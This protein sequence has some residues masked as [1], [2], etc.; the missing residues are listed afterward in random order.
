MAA[1]GIAG[2]V[3]YQYKLARQKVAW[4]NALSIAESG[5]NYYQWHLA[6]NPED[7]QDG[8]GQPG[9]YLHDYQDPYGGTTGQFSLEITAPNSCSNTITI[10]STGWTSGAPNTQRSA[11]IKYGKKSLAD[12]AFL[13]N[14][15]AWFGPDE[16]LHGPVHSNGGI[17]QDGIN[18]SKMTSAKETYTCQP[19]HDCSPSQTKPG[20]W[21]AGQEDEL[22]EFPVSN[23]DF[24]AL[25]VDFADLK[26]IAE[27]QNL[28]FSNQGLGYHINFK[29][30][31]T[32]DLYK[33]TKLKNPVWSWNMED[34][35]RERWDIQTE[36]FLN[37]YTVPSECAI[38]FIEDNVWVSG[39]VNGRVTLAAGKLPDVPNNRRSIIINDNIVYQQKNGDDVLG[40][41]A[42]KDILV[43][44]YSAPDDLEIN[45]AMIAQYGHIYRHYYYYPW[46]YYL[47]NTI[48]VYGSIITNQTWTWTWVNGSS[49]TLDGYDQTTSIYDSN[50]IYAPPPSFP[51]TGQ[52]TFISWDEK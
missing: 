13:T 25:T 7:Y 22:W 47:K 10:K 45:A 28:Y 24:E 51:T 27:G 42:Q 49:V 34:W 11:Q 21:G 26:S 6:H 30:D 15:D 33:V 39:T 17:R 2:V 3:N 9:P 41:I 38:I 19:Y 44:L 8:T 43:P 50:A 12:Y 1:V 5:L 36:S 23:V 4:H 35:V 18:D 32:F 40:L 52:Y 37:N 20:V 29:S 48:T 16:T 31:G 14:T 46:P